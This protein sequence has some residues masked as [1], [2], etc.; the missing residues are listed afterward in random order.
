MNNIHNST[1]S[2]SR[3]E[4]LLSRLT[5][6]LALSF[7]TVAQAAPVGGVVTAGGASISSNAGNTNI[8]QT[9]S[10]AVINW[11]GFNVGP[12]ESVKFSQ[13]NS[14]AVILNRV[15]SPNASTILGNITANGKVFLINPNGILFGQ[16]AS[17]NVG[18][19]VASTLGISDANFMAG[20][21]KFSG[22]SSAAVINQGTLSTN[23]DGGYI[24][25]LGA[26]VT[27]E[28]VIA[29]RLGTVALAAGTAITLDVA[30]DNLLNVTVDQGAVDALVRNGN[31]VKADGGQVIM[32]A[33]GAS[34]LL[35]NAVNNTGVI[36]AQSIQ[37]QNGIIRLSAGP[38][39]GV[40]NAGGTLD[41][42]G[43]GTGQTGGKVEVLG[44]TVNLVNAK[45]NASGD[46]GGGQVLVG[47]NFKGAGPQPNSLNTNIDTTTVIKAD[48]IRSGDGGR[49]AV[50]SDGAT[51]VAGVLSARGGAQ[52]G[53]GGFIET[54]G[55]QLTLTNTANVN[56]MAPNGKTGMWLLDPVN[57]TIATS[58][59]DETPAQVTT[60]LAST[61][62]TITATNDI[63]VNDPVTWSTPQTLTLNAG[64]DVKINAPITASTAGAKV[65]LVGGNDVLIN[66]DITSSGLNNQIN[67][68]A[69]RDITALASTAITA[70]ASG[71]QVNLTSGR[72]ISVGTVTAAGSG[73]MILKADRN[74]TVGTATAVG[75]VS[76][77]ADNDGSGP[78]VAGGTVTIGTNVTA[79]NTII[80]FNPATYAATATE[81]AAYTAKIVGTK[82]IKAWVFTQAN[83]K[84]YDT[85]TAATLSFNGTPTD[86]SAVTLNAGTATFD[87][88]N[89]G[90]GKTVTYSGYSL[91]GT[92]TNLVLFAAAGTHTANITP[93]SLTI[94]ATGTNKVYDGNTTDAVTLSGAALAG[95]TVT[96]ANSAANFVDKN[97]GIAKT[98]NVTGITL[99]GADAGN[100][101][102]NSTTTTTANITQAT[103][104]ISATGNDKTF[105]GTTT[106]TTTLSDNRIAG[107]TFSTSYTAANFNTAAV[108]TSKPISVTGISASGTDAGNYIYNTTATSSANI[109][110]SSTTS[111]VV[112]PDGSIVFSNGTTV[113][114]TGTIVRPDGTVVPVSD[115]T[116]LGR[117]AVVPVIPTDITSQGPYV[118]RRDTQ[119]GGIDATPIVPLSMMGITSGL[120]LSAENGFDA[121]PAKFT[122]L[123][124]THPGY[125]P[126]MLAVVEAPRP[127][128]LQS[129][130]P[131]VPARQAVPY[132]APYRVPKQGRN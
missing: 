19:M 46:A 110:A 124:G 99:G 80:R 59:G 68:T 67:V 107:D 5:L 82:D 3:Y 17:V 25:L 114:P 126:G 23:I 112:L 38:E 26:N 83:N 54:S 108:G 129:F 55:K 72:D 50:W 123:T 71:T 63:N 10:K 53:N 30:G 47:G 103:L 77:L 93:A 51:V 122:M 6:A 116:S 64:H 22:E 104:I 97:V 115:T 15:S 31:L 62:R 132:F 58:G 95:D 119:Y 32:T 102:A 1:Q 65:V 37:N 44:R 66:A 27:N 42:S 28:G 86:A 113:T 92:A 57:W 36:Q 109:T 13:P 61:D 29:A 16:G 100:Y 8:V 12:T 75:T 117:L 118:V 56:T 21:Y 91:G 49:I 41:V 74:I 105:D 2:V 18:G 45:I 121:G 4:L 43:T 128:E 40:V 79:A 85:T 81:V 11:Q 120:A 52:A 90:D 101:T 14:S 48:A 76:L 94:S 127:A 69:T 24:A 35:S 20:N 73:S 34:S 130:S 87:T 88:K 70:S 89:V 98:V 106:T 33:R 60:S 96:F 84:V 78:G 9:T 7:A 111:S 125:A 131:V 39:A